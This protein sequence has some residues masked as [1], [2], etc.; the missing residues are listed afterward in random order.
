MA[1]RGVSADNAYK[2]QA[3]IAGRYR[4][5]ITRGNPLHNQV[6]HSSFGKRR[7]ACETNLDLWLDGNLYPLDPA[8]RKRP[9]FQSPGE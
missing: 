2:V 3:W 8:S 5:L 6:S 7:K 4:P 9:K 1:L